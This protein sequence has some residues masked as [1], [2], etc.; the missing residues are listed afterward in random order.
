LGLPSG[1]PF[2]F[3][4]S[5]LGVSKW[6]SAN[7][8]HGIDLLVDRCEYRGDSLWFDISQRVPAKLAKKKNARHLS[9]KYCDPAIR[10]MW[11]S[12][13]QL[14]FT[15]AVKD[16]P[17]DPNDRMKKGIPLDM[18]LSRIGSIEMY[19]RGIAF[20]DHVLVQEIIGFRIS[21]PGKGDSFLAS[22][23]ETA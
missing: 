3:I 15:L 12:V 2:L 10:S 21:S 20:I 6:P 9:W 4:Q 11:D 1:G 22:F 13:D 7:Q 18:E 23:K 5:E 14:I 17:L 8:P 16:S 19:V